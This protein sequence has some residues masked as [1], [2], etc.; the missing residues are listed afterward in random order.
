MNYTPPKQTDLTLT[1]TINASP[2]EVYDVWL[3]TTSPGGPWFGC[4]RVILDAKVD[5]L[6]YHCGEHEGRDWA[7]YGRFVALDRPHR[8]E[9]TWMSEGTRGLE[10]VVTLTLEPDG[11]KTRLTLRHAGVPDDDFGRQHKDGW[12][13]MLGVIEDRFARR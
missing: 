13:W 5:G 9:H 12:G 7:H 4:K 3:D 1:R 10:S 2:A 6:F 11:N 8:I